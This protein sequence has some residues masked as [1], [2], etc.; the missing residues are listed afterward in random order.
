MNEIGDE[1]TVTFLKKDGNHSAYNYEYLDF[2]TDG[3]WI[4][5]QTVFK[6]TVRAI[7]VRTFRKYKE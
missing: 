1:Q 3:K 2:N 7:E 6:D 5:R 4:K